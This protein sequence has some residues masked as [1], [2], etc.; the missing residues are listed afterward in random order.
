MRV[1]WEPCAD[2]TN[3]ACARN[4]AMLPMLALGSNRRLPSA[5]TFRLSDGETEARTAK[6]PALAHPAEAAGWRRAA[7]APRC[8]GGARGTQSTGEGRRGGAARPRADPGAP[9]GHSSVPSL[10]PAM[11][12]LLR[13][14]NGIIEAFGRYAGPGTGG[15]CALTRGQLKR[16]LERELA[17]II[18]VGVPARWGARGQSGS[19]RARTRRFASG[20]QG[21]ARAPWPRRCGRRSRWEQGTVTGV[22]RQALEEVPCPQFILIG[23]QGERTLRGQLGEGHGFALIALRCF[24][25]LIL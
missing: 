4:T 15:R 23:R 18:V 7:R 20:T 10:T 2:A 5:L 25:N 13:N 19:P 11:P 22:D 16:L 24:R 8:P 1:P 12:Q 9:R 14:I 3:R 21:Q 6:Q 17:D